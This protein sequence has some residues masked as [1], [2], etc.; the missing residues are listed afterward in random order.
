[1]KWIKYSESKFRF[2]DFIYE[3]FFRFRFLKVNSLPLT[4]RDN[5]Y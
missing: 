5:M 4:L 1:M 2:D 3:F